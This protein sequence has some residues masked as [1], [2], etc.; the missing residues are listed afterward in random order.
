MCQRGGIRGAPGTL[1]VP[2]DRRRLP[3][4]GDW[5]VGSREDGETVTGVWISGEGTTGAQYLDPTVPVSLEF[6]ADRVRRVKCLL[7]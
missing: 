5:S 7:F 3:E 4:V 6:L 2:F 1:W